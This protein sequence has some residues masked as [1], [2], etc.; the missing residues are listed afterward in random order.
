AQLALSQALA[1]TG[2]VRGAFGAATAAAELLPGD[3]AAREALADAHWLANEDAAA[4]AE[5]RALAIELEGTGRDRVI[6]K[7]RTL[8]RQQAGWGGRLLAA[9]GP[10]F[11]VTLERGWLR[12]DR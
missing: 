3:P 5:F 6:R 8:Y 1:R 7:A 11:R 2:D 12:I 9:I 4:F 10:A